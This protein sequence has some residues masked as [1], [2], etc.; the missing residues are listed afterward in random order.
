MVLN[1]LNHLIYAV[2]FVVRSTYYT[3]VG[4]GDRP[5]YY[6]SFF[7]EYLLPPGLSSMC[8]WKTGYDQAVVLSTVMAAN[9]GEGGKE[10]FGEVLASFIT[11]P[12]FMFY[13][14]IAEG[15]FH[16]MICV[17]S[18]W[19]LARSASGLLSLYRAGLWLEIIIM[20]IPYTISFTLLGLRRTIPGF[21]CLMAWAVVLHH[22]TVLP[23]FVSAYCEWASDRAAPDMAAKRK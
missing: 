1:S 22:L 10:V 4:S 18:L 11:S 2:L 16:C 15:T 23:D 14:Q 13:Y 17:G 7:L 3:E 20:D 5:F 6:E 8:G 21:P 19:L 9:S 12:E